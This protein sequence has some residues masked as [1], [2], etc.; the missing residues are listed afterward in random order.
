M[1]STPPGRIFVSYAR[2]DQERVRRIAELLSC[3]WSVWWDEEVPPGRHFDQVIEEVLNAACCVVVVWSSASIKSHWVRAEAAEGLARHVLIP[4]KI[5]EV[6]PPLQFRQ[7]QTVNLVGWDGRAVTREV[8]R[9]H[10]A[11]AGLHPALVE[12]A[13]GA[14]SKAS[15]LVRPQISSP[16]ERL[17]CEASTKPATAAGPSPTQPYTHHLAGDA[18]LELV[19]IPAGRFRMGDEGADQVEV[20][21]SRGFWMGKYPVTQRQFEMVMGKNP[22]HFQ[23]SGPDA[24]V[25][26]VSWD[27]ANAFCRRLTENLAVLGRF[28]ELEYRLPTEAEWEYACRAGSRTRF[29]FG[30]SE[31]QLGDYAWDAANSG[32]ATHPVGQKKAN[33]WG[34]HDLHGNVR[35]WCQDWLHDYP[36]GPVTNPTGPAVAPAAS[37]RRNASP[38]PVTVTSLRLGTTTSV[39]GSSWRP[40]QMPYN[41]EH[42][43]AGCDARVVASGGQLG[44]EVQRTVQHAPDLDAVD[45]LAVEDEVAAVSFNAPRT[46]LGESKVGTATSCTWMPREELEGVV[47][48]DQKRTR[49]ARIVPSDVAGGALEIAEDELAL[50]PARVHPRLVRIFWMWVRSPG[51]KRPLAA[52]ASLSPACGGVSGRSAS[53]LTSWG[54]TK[55]SSSALSD[56]D[57]RS[58][59]CL[60]SITVLTTGS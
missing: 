3:S 53:W 55:A 10:A 14:H 52:S 58:M 57:N 48:G 9:L 26:Q 44:G 21:L 51:R 56:G 13:V 6:A 24:P 22:S 27:E 28:S 7:L 1:E 25:D 35:E 42:G 5:D 8:E 2:V 11:V 15:L 30:D 54:H 32:G 41:R 49:C 12:E 23:E 59:A 29:C 38:L 18:R 37:R 60:I 40:S 45:G 43:E 33:A 47:S 46:N 39:S 17:S 20:T 34:V 50:R 16:D 19:W 36:Q 4:V 31:S